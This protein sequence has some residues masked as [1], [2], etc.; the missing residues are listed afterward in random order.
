[1]NYISF[2]KPDDDLKFGMHVVKTVYG[3]FTYDLSHVLF[4]LQMFKEN[5]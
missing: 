1:M 3:D 4:I 2:L 5:G